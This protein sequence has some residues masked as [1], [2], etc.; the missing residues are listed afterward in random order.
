[1]EAHISHTY[2]SYVIDP[3]V[4]G[5]DASIWKTVSGTPT[6]VA[7]KYRLNAAEMLT[8]TQYRYG[9]FEFNLTVPVAPTAG[10]NRV[11]GVSEKALINR[12][13]IAFNFDTTGVL[14]AQVY[15]KYGTSLFSEA[16]PWNSAWT[17][18]PTLFR[19]GWNGNA[20]VFTVSSVT[21]ANLYTTTFSGEHYNIRL[22]M[23]VD[24]LN[25][26]AD[27]LD[28]ASVSIIHTSPG[29]P[30]NSG[31][32]ITSVTPG[33]GATNLGK[34]EDTPHVTGDVGVE[35]LSVRRST[36]VTSADTA[37]DY[38][39]INTD[40]NGNEWVTMGTKQA[41]EDITADVTKVE[42]RNNYTYIL[43]ATT[44]VVKTGSGLLHTIT[45][46]GGTTGTITV[47]D[48]T[49]A[50]GTKIA[51]FTTTNSLATYVFDVAFATGCT[52]VTSAA[53]QLTLSVR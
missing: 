36:P 33:V 20:I 26:N 32:S 27:N 10:D 53:T 50:S 9:D 47:Y 11:I 46:E 28:V 44:T 39:T 18:T 40:D 17:N 30:V 21:G 52:V 42:Q 51:D 1:M 43:T 24:I 16:I 22:P 23:A 7:N 29:S 3:Q 35:M 6:V 49:A 8:Y 45:V 4:Y 31:S 48:N 38:A 14:F 12:G 34:A 13:R 37:G 5:L 41:G 2:V 19:I 15:G 25:A